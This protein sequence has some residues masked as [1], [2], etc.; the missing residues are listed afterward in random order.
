MS[1]NYKLLGCEILRPETENLLASPDETRRYECEWLE[2]GWHENPDAL[3]AELRRRI[4][5]CADKGYRAVLLLFGLCSRAT[6]GLCPPPDSRL[7]IPRVHDCVS[8]HLGSAR[9]YLDEQ[10]AEPGTYWFSRGFL[11]KSGG[12]WTE[13]L[14]MGSGAWL[15]GLGDGVTSP[16]ALR[17]RLIEEYGEDNADYLYETLVEGWKKNYRRGVYLEWESNPGREEERGWAEAYAAKHGWAFT[18][19]PVDLRLLRGLL[20][21]PWPEDEFVTVLPGQCLVATNGEDAL[22]AAAID[23]PACAAGS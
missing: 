5:A 7:V 17:A 8:L 11:R 4:A 1:E 13:A 3:N 16:E 19:R 18:D 6:A 15:T 2:L 22:R 14:G 10:D 12:E 9:R 23:E 20:N 21:G